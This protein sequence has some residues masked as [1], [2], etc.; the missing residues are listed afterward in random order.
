M[1]EYLIRMRPEL[2]DRIKLYAKHYNW[3][4]RYT[5]IRF[6]KI[7]YAECMKDETD[8]YGKDRYNG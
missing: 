7:G 1:K 6:I 4:I 2:F 5:I 3:T 8:Y